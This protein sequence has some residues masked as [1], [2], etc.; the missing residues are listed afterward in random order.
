MQSMCMVIIVS[1]CVVG[2]YRLLI[3]REICVDDVERVVVRSVCTNIHSLSGERPDK[4]SETER[5]SK[6]TGPGA[7]MCGAGVYNHIKD[8]YFQNA[9]ANV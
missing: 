3:R 2:P 8:G 9:V 4:T 6:S 7:C 1:S 5:F